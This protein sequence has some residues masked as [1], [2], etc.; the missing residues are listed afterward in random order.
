MDS[1]ASTTGKVVTGR[2]SRFAAMQMDLGNMIS[3]LLP[4]LP[5]LWFGGSMVIYA[6]HR[7]HPNPRVGHF[8]QRAAYRFYGV[9]GAIIPIGT[10]FPGRGVT[11][12]L[13]AWG[14][15]LAVIIPW[16]L[17]SIV[18]IRRETWPDMVVPEAD[19]AAQDGPEQQVTEPEPSAEEQTP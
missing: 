19:E 18:Q 6:L 13:V 9:M 2:S 17:W 15:G 5:L 16:S 11:S 4:P 12:W 1:E 3:M 14:V 8:T 7:H 10:F